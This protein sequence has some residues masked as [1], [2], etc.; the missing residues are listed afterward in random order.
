MLLLHVLHIICQ[1]SDLFFIYLN[2]LQG[3]TEH[4][5]CLY[6]NIDGLLNTLMFMNNMFVYI[7][8]FIFSSVEL[9]HNMWSL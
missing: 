1:N 3:V 8:Q 9:V 4:Q 5:Q 2:H 7:I 6:R